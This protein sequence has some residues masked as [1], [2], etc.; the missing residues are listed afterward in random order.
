MDAVAA[1]GEVGTCREHVVQHDDDAVAPW[2]GR[3][4]SPGGDAAFESGRVAGIAS[5]V[6]LAYIVDRVDGTS[7]EK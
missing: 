6:R 5:L 4:A 7:R 1:R 2:S 3:R